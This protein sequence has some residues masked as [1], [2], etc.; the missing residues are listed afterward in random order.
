MEHHPGAGLEHPEKLQPDFC[1]VLK[2]QGSSS[3]ALSRNEAF[4]CSGLL[5]LFNPNRTDVVLK[6]QVRWKKEIE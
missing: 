2:A 6:S 5:L 3:R 4:I 1:F